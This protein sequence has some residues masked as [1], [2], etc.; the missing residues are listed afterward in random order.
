MCEVVR[1]GAWWTAK[2]FDL[3]SARPCK[4]KMGK[5]RLQGDN[6]K[7]ADAAGFCESD[8]FF[9]FFIV[10]KKKAKL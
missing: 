10:R 1:Y 8:A 2:G 7:Q 6:A 4:S 5:E 9:N 3:R